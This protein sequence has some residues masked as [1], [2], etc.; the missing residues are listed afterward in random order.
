MDFIN[1]I[2]LPT[3]YNDFVTTW[4]KLDRNKKQIIMNYVDNIELKLIKNNFYEIDKVNFRSTFY[5]NWKELF[6]EGVID[7][8]IPAY[9]DGV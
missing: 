9:T 7:T 5:K 1:R 8:K 6:D 4:N 3:L 2:K